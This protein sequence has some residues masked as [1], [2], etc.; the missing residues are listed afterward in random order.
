MAT[1]PATG[2]VAAVA[3]AVTSIVNEI[4]QFE[5]LHNTP[6]MLTA[7]LSA[8]FQRQKDAA[9]KAVLNEDTATVEKGISG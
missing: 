4:A 3:D 7:A 2:S 5:S 1:T 9:V 8:E 6:G